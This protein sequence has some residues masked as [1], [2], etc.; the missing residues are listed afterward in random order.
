VAG[1]NSATTSNLEPSGGAVT[2]WMPAFTSRKS[3]S[4][5][6]VWL[7]SAPP[8][9]LTTRRGT[10]PSAG[11]SQ[12]LPWTAPDTAGEKYRILKRIYGAGGHDITMANPAVP[13]LSFHYTRINQITDDISDA[14]VYGGIHFR[15]DQEAGA[16]LGRD[17]GTY[18]YKHNLRRAKQ[19]DNDDDGDNQDEHDGRSH[20][21]D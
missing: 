6:S 10:P 15:F 18:V 3:A 19:A 1:A 8:T 4:R 9:L 20:R 2:S 17:I 14:R 21:R 16:D 11:I 12:M 13:G 5:P 7:T